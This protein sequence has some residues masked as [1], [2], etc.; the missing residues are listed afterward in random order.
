VYPL[1]RLIRGGHVRLPRAPVVAT[2]ADVAASAAAGVGAGG[3]IP[4]AKMKRLYCL[5][6]CGSHFG[7]LRYLNTSSMT[8]P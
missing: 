2:L 5:A 6:L 3:I 1:D 7:P 4:P 8:R